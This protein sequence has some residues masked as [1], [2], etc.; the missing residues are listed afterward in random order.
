MLKEL[1]TD[2]VYYRI[3][4]R[5]FTKSSHVYRKYK[6][7]SNE[8]EIDNN[9]KAIL[10][11]LAAN[12]ILILNQTHGNTV[13][14]ADTIQNIGEVEPEGDAA[15]TAT[16]NLALAIQTADCVPVLLYC[17]KGKV[18][19]AAHCGWKSAKADIIINLI[20]QMRVAEADIIAAVIGPAIQQSSY[21][22]DQQYYQDFVNQQSDYQ[23]FFI[24]STKANHY[25]F[26]LPSFV[27]MKLVA[28]GVNQIT[29]ISEDT[30]TSP[31]KY[32]S[33]R[34][35]CHLGKSL[36]HSILSTIIIK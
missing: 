9:L 35:S 11:A 26:D 18:I 13:I 21:E 3:F 23:R 28:S 14:D 20:D 32:P 22:V 10:A 24:P 33:Y 16:N 1:V 17:I 4:D 36:Q 5:E 31:T 6:P 34:R 27:E 15:V 29:K 19:G 30:Y 25:M 7:N 8:A 2:K 12:D